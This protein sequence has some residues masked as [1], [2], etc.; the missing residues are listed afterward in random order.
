MV[1]ISNNRLAI[2]QQI[3][4]NNEILD[5][6]ESKYVHP[7]IGDNFI[8]AN[9]ILDDHQRA[10]VPS[11]GKLPLDYLMLLINFYVDDFDH[12]PEHQ[13]NILHGPPDC[14]GITLIGSLTNEQTNKQLY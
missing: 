10:P 5:K 2:P 4:D 14:Y 6:D 12:S 11:H 3:S 7:S 9:S 8:F 13:E 1:G